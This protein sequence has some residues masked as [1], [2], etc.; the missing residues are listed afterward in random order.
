[1]SIH[2]VNLL[3]EK[4]N[5]SNKYQFTSLFSLFL[6]ISR[7]AGWCEINFNLILMST[8]NITSRPVTRCLAVR[9]P[10]GQ[11]HGGAP[12]SH[13]RPRRQRPGSRCRGR[14]GH[15]GV[16]ARTAVAPRGGYSP[17]LWWMTR[18][19]F[20][21]VA[22]PHNFWNREFHNKVPT[23]SNN[24]QLFQPNQ[25]DTRFHQSSE[26]VNISFS[27][28]VFLRGEHFKVACS[29][30]KPPVWINAYSFAL[31]CTYSCSDA[32]TSVKAWWGAS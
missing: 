26:D 16:T 24:K 23:Q 20:D 10:R 18:T 28:L 5:L 17:Q 32:G 19:S 21:T 13:R 31:Y 25:I 12:Q 11:S 22:S 14:G 7:A 15:A 6:L 27:W 3:L 30:V 8:Q 1:M 4:K 2:K 29:W 9:P